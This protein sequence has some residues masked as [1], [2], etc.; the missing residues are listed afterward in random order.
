M[1]VCSCGIN[2]P[3]EPLFGHNDHRIVMA[4]SVLASKVGGVIDGA[5]A[6]N[7]SYPSFFEDVRGLGVEVHGEI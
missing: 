7:K 3:T 2:K 4:L 1:R 5:A 6:V